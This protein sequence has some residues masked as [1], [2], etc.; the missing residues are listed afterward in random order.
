MILFLLVFNDINRHFCNRSS[1][2]AIERDAKRCNTL[3]QTISNTHASKVTVQQADFLTLNPSDY[4][5]V[6]YILVDPSCSGTG[7]IS[8][9]KWV[10]QDG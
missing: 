6:K 1:I 4:Q 7:K 10:A 2:I 8:V 9:Q 3:R 5:D